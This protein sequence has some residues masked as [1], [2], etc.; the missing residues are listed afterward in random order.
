M[1][2]ATKSHRDN[3]ST[4]RLKQRMVAEVMGMAF[5]TM[6]YLLQVTIGTNKRVD[7]RVLLIRLI[8]LRDPR[9]QQRKEFT[10]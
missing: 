10:V 4:K 1:G 9:K 6:L 3:R 7:S 5:K 8:K 2:G